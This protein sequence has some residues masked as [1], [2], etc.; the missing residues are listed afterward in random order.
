MEIFETLDILVDRC[1]C[2]MHETQLY[3]M[4]DSVDFS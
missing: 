1:E 4:L 2:E 3:D